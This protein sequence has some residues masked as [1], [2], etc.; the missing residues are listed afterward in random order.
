MREKP[1]L[2]KAKKQRKKHFAPQI[3]R[4]KKKKEKQEVGN[5]SFGDNNN[6]SKQ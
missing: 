2:S 6:F 1:T 5:D 3:V 4:I